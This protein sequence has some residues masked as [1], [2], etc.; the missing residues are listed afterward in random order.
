MQE[1]GFTDLLALGRALDSAARVEALRLLSQEGSLSAGE[2]A[3][4]LGL[5]P[6]AM[7]GHIRRL[8]E[9]GLVDVENANGAHGVRRMVRLRQKRLALNLE[10]APEAERSYAVELP[11]GAYAAHRVLPTCGLAAPEG[12]IGQVDDPRAFDDPRHFSAGVLWLLEGYVEYRIP[13]RIPRGG[14]LKSLSIVQEIASEAPGTCGDWPSRIA[15]SLGGVEVGSWV[16]P[17]DYG[18]RRG[19]WNPP[20]WNDGLNQYGLR[21]TLRVDAA[22]AFMDG[23]RIGSV[24]AADLPLRGGEALAYRM[25]VAADGHG[26]GLTLFGRGFGNYGRD[27]AVSV[28]YE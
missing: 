10:A 21:K 16:S 26:G 22:G 1:F 20:W 13:N 7:T 24:T 14:R 27:I 17:G 3:Q 5:T 2:L 4:K 11:V 19:L 15:F 9:A 28:E 8:Q 23:E 6:G 12:W 18:D 25:Q